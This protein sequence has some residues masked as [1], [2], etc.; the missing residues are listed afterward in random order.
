M[1]NSSSNSNGSPSSSR[2]S[3]RM[4]NLINH[5]RADANNLPYHLQ[6]MG[7]ATNSNGDSNKFDSNNTGSEERIL[8][9]LVELGNGLHIL[10]ENQQFGDLESIQE[11]S[12]NKQE[13][14]QGE[15]NGLQDQRTEK[16]IWQNQKENKRF[17]QIFAVPKEEMSNIE[18]S[19][20]CDLANAYRV[21]HD[22]GLGMNV[23]LDLISAKITS[24]TF[25]IKPFTIRFDEVNP[26]NLIKV[27]IMDKGMTSRGM[28]AGINPEIVE[29]FLR[30]HVPLYVL[31]P[32]IKSVV[33]SNH[34]DSTC[35]ASIKDGF[36]PMCEESRRL[37]DQIYS[38]SNSHADMFIRALRY[39][40]DKILHARGRKHVQAWRDPG[41]P[42]SLSQDDIRKIPPIEDR[43]VWLVSNLGFVCS[44]ETI[45]SS[46]TRSLV[47][48]KNCTM[49]IR[50][51]QAVGGDISRLN[52]STSSSLSTSMTSILARLSR[53]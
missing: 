7:S 52:T 9:D 36:I 40:Q 15:K 47:V 43:C 3:R 12:W 48:S 25:L 42:S 28:E 32:Q 26:Y 22:N 6:F 18:W 20:R 30:L 16:N 38:S 13:V 23:H 46:I 39:K 24:C 10:Q 37:G 17:A 33:S 34:I 50:A 21:A 53:L 27:D 2:A 41:N 4:K 35:V 49:Q 44:G 31:Q 29:S 11:G 51:M 1:S 19:L 5:L 45:A 8:E 14:W